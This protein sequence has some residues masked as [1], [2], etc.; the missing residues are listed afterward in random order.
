MATRKAKNFARLA[1][2]IEQPNQYRWQAEDLV[3][4][5]YTQSPDFE[6]EVQRVMQELKRI[7]SSVEL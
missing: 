1:T 3:R 4:A 7:A 5:S 6:R 2:A